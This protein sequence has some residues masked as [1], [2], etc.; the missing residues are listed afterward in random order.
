MD[1]S[2]FSCS[3]NFKGGSLSKRGVCHTPTL[4]TYIH[5]DRDIGKMHH[6]DRHKG[7]QQQLW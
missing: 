4:F 5:T 2:G 7:Q 6:W 1:F 3:D